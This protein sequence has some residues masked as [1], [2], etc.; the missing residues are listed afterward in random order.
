M[1]S[2]VNFVSRA[3]PALYSSTSVHAS[4]TRP[5]CCLG[6]LAGED[7]LVFE[8]RVEDCTYTIARRDTPPRTPSFDHT[9]SSAG[10]PFRDRLPVARL[11]PGDSVNFTNHHF[12]FVVLAV[13]PEDAVTATMP[14]THVSQH[15]KTVHSDHVESLTV[16][17]HTNAVKSSPGDANNVSEMTES[18]DESEG[19]FHDSTMSNV[20]AKLS[21][22]TPATEPTTI[23][24][25]EESSQ[26]GPKAL[27]TVAPAS[28]GQVIDPHS[29]LA[30]KTRESQSQS[31]DNGHLSDSQ[32]AQPSDELGEI[33]FL[34]PTKK[35][36]YTYGSRAVSEAPLP[37]TSDRDEHDTAAEAATRTIRGRKRKLAVVD[38]GDSSHEE[39]LSPQKKLKGSAKVGLYDA[40]VVLPTKLRSITKPATYSEPQVATSRSVSTVS[41][42]NIVVAPLTTKAAGKKSKRAAQ[43]PRR[44]K[45]KL[46]AATPLTTPSAGTTSASSVSSTALDGKVPKVLITMS[47]KKDSE[48]LVKWLGEQGVV[49]VDSVPSKRTHF[50]CVVPANKVP[51]TAKTLRTLA[52][53]KQVVTDDWLTD[54][55]AQGQLLDPPDYVHQDFEQETGIDR[56]KLFKGSTIF[57]T[58][59][60]A[61]EFCSWFAG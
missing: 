17:A 45:D 27:M 59:K 34:A 48:P 21:Y 60:L 40:V 19:D 7:V 8:P 10:T 2:C 30:K 32:A 41:D 37:T 36:K 58:R 1:T 51:K 31:Q 61:T 5:N 9:C 28:S 44:T 6:L 56:S 49:I 25:V 55:M 42:D 15:A 4:R 53:G 20:T 18:E 46:R 14:Q 38:Q 3:P 24:T 29:P 54:S 13:P 23:G 52:Q 22:L 16:A 57:F 47:D 50:V 11:Q 39:E 26:S 35:L 33:D 43:T 12:G